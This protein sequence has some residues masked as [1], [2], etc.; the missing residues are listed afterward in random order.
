MSGVSYQPPT[1]NLTEFNSS[2]FKTANESTLTLSEA[3]ALFL[4]RTGT[5]SS[6]ATST[7]FNG[8]IN[9]GGLILSSSGNSG[10]KSAYFSTY[11]TPRLRAV[12]IGSLTSLADDSTCIG[13]SASAS[14]YHSVAVGRSA[15]SGGDTS[16]AIGSSSSASG[17]KSTAIGSGATTS[18]ANEIVLGTETEYV[19]CPGTSATNGSLIAAADIYVNGVRAGKGNTA[20]VNN[21][22]FGRD[23]LFTASTSIN[24]SAFGRDA[25]KLCSGTSA[26]SGFGNSAFGSFSL[27]A[28]TTGTRNVGIGT[29]SLGQSG[30]TALNTGNRNTGCGY[31]A[32]YIITG[33]GSDNTYV[34]CHR[35]SSTYT[36]GSTNTFVGSQSIL[37]PGNNTLLTVNASTSLGAFTSVGGFSNSTAIGGGTSAAIPGAVCTAANQ[38]MLG[39]STETVEC[40]GTVSSISLKTA[41]N[42]SINGKV[43]GIGAGGANTHSLFCGLTTGG[44]NGSNNSIYGSGSYAN[45][46]D[47][48]SAK[49]TIIGALAMTST[50]TSF[51]D[52]TVLGYNCQN[53]GLTAGTADRITLL[54]STTSAATS[55]STAIGYGATSTLANQI[56]L[57]TSTEFVEC[58]GTDNTNGCLKLNGGLK[59]QTTYGAVPSSTMLGHRI[60]LSAIAINPI[61]SLTAVSIGSL[62]LTVGV[63]SLNYTFELSSGGGNC[64]ATIQSFYFSNASGGA[65][66]TRINNTGTNRLHF[67]MGYGSGDNP[68]YSGGGTYYASAAISLYPTLL[69]TYSGIGALTGTGYASAVRIG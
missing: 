18:V 2:V 62:A 23:A 64:I 57:G 41:R 21:T 24:N 19:S 38:I 60:A 66:A 11:T 31:A 30:A 45:S 39:R 54:G 3:Q 50:A 44:G 26:T 15:S 17:V 48:S 8:V 53:T 7:T 59:L 52:V 29:F 58:A 63:W 43:F 46:G 65:Y 55:D 25:L 36:A 6:T 67:S 20:D 5:P 12:N 69:I 32:G 27:Q 10:N 16:T 22:C 1:E 14:G 9:V 40:V 42:L 34:G 4:G 33:A 35:E 47:G 37:G 49:N 51:N 68:A 56:M 61:T 28:L 13:Y